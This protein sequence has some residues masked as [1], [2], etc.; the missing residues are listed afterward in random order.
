M[1]DL[2]ALLIVDLIRLY[3]DSVSKHEPLPLYDYDAIEELWFEPL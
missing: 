1:R 2:E 3:V